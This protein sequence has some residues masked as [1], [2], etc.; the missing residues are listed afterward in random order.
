[1]LKPLTLPELPGPPITDTLLFESV[2]MGPVALVLVGLVVFAVMNSRGTG[3]KGL[4]ILGAFLALAGGNAALSLAVQTDREAMRTNTRELVA[5][6]AASDAASLRPLLHDQLWLRNIPTAPDSIDREGLIEL[7]ER[8]MRGVAA[9]DQHRVREVKATTDGPG[10]GRSLALVW[11][12]TAGQG[13]PV[14][15]TWQLDWQR[16]G[17]DGPWKLAGLEMLKLGGL[18]P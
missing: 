4:L 15:S 9:V 5:A 8:S 14:N 7:V 3:G 17:N 11:V 1:M 13:I 2:W 10:V 16:D 6:V 18:N 12:S